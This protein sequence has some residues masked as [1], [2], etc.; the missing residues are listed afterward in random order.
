MSRKG[1]KIIAIPANVT[2][3]INPDKVI[4][5]GPKGELTVAT[6]SVVKVEQTA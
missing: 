1:N 4:V 6:P 2:L 5:K 3:T